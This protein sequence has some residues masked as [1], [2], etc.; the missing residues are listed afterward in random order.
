[1]AIGTKTGAVTGPIPAEARHQE[2]LRLERPGASPPTG[3]QRI[4]HSCRLRKVLILASRRLGCCMTQ[5]DLIRL[6][7]VAISGRCA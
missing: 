5:L 1:M 7:A 2:D 3:L 6:A 4:L